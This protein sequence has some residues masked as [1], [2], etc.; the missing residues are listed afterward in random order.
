MLVTQMLG[1]LWKKSHLLVLTN[2]I[3]IV[4]ALLCLAVGCT[5][6]AVGTERRVVSA[7][8]PVR[9]LWQK[10]L[11]GRIVEQP[12]LTGNTVVVVASDALVA[13]DLQSGKQRW[14]QTTVPYSYSFHL[15]ANQDRILLGDSEGYVTAY[16]IDSGAT[17]WKHRV[18][19]GGNQFIADLVTT[20]DLAFVVAQPTFLEALD[21]ETGDVKWQVRGV[22]H[23]I[24]TRGPGLLLTEEALYLQAGEELLRIDQATGEILQ[25]TAATSAGGQ[26][27]KDHLYTSTAIYN[28]EPFQ[29]LREIAP[30]TIKLLGGNCNQFNVP[31][32]ADRYIY[33]VG[34]CGGVFAF[35]EAGN[36]VWQYQEKLAAVA[37]MALL[38]DDLYVLYRNGQIHAIDALT[39]ENKGVL[40]SNLAISGV[41]Y[42]N[43]NARG[44]TSSG[45]VLIVTFNDMNIWALGKK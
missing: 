30:P 42:G 20:D 23:H 40:E 16:T 28:V 32:V 24:E 12:L 25:R 21:L 4:V 11:T 19:E 14:Q 3:I 43:P 10:K 18:G 26:L 37:P 27:I 35:D 22:N 31:Y 1:K 45:S 39:A 5:E 33:G 44:L 2:L 17:L 38:G 29:K 7:A 13:F 8:L 41:T 6:A 9:L 15:A 34:H 36:T